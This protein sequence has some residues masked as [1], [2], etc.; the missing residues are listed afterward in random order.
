MFKGM[1]LV[2]F[3]PFCFFLLSESIGCLHNYMCMI[4]SDVKHVLKFIVCNAIES[5]VRSSATY[6]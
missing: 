4:D 2:D 6:K 5:G 3:D 1:E